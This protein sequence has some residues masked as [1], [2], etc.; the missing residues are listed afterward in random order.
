[1]PVPAP[2]DAP[3]K[4]VETFECVICYE[5][6]KG[7]GQITLG[8]SHA[9]CLGCYTKETQRV[10]ALRQP[11]KC[12]ICRKAV[13]LTDEITPQE[14]QEVANLVQLVNQDTRRVAE[15][16]RQIAEQTR[17]RDEIQHLV[18][19]RTA[20][21]TRIARDY[22][23]LDEALAAVAA[24]EPLPRPAA[25][26][27]GGGGG[28]GFGL[29]E[30]VPVEVFRPAPA[31]AARAV[32]LRAVPPMPAANVARVAGDDTARCPGCRTYVLHPDLRYRH[33]PM[34][35]GDG[36]HDRRLKRCGRCLEVQ[37]RAA[38]IWQN[39]H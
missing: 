8:C 22:G 19:E 29:G 3:H 5:D 1:M 25:G 21:M 36:I 32:P 14:R 11:V 26:G 20:E 38:I 15:Y 27:G 2:A 18:V 28:G 31:P 35:E 4:E 13:R 23:I 10:A 33:M 16:N 34:V 30:P 7:T 9:I 12:P 37:R 6:G 24:D 39:A 17:V